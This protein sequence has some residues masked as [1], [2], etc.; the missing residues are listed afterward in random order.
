MGERCLPEDSDNSGLLFSELMR[1]RIYK[2]L[3]LFH[4]NC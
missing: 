4:A 2:I 3:D 1:G